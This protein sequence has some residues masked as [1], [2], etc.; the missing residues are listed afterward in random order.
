MTR[1]LMAL[2]AVCLAGCAWY[3][4]TGEPDPGDDAICRLDSD[5]LEAWICVHG[6]CVEAESGPVL[7]PPTFGACE[8]DADCLLVARAGLCCGPSGPGDYAAV[9]RDR[10]A[11]WREEH[12]C[13]DVMCEDC[14]YCPESVAHACW[15]EE[16]LEAVCAPAPEGLRC[17]AQVADP[18]ACQSDED[19]VEVDPPC[20]GC[21]VGSGEI[22]LNRDWVAA[23][24]L[25]HEFVCANVDLDCGGG[26]GCTDLPPACV[27]ERCQAASA[28]ACYDV[29]DPVCAWLDW[30]QMETF[31]NAC[32]AEC[33][34][35]EWW[36]RGEC[37]AGEGLNCGGFAGWPC[38]D[39]DLYCT[40]PGCVCANPYA[41]LCLPPGV[42]I[43][44]ED[45]LMQNLTHDACEGDWACAW[46]TCE[47][48][49]R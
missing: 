18:R 42:C 26:Q 32:E 16:C 30:E 11:D 21:E 17:M 41:G 36:H 9:H 25:L 23:W 13:A 14:G 45:C 4:D 34:G 44:A 12:G 29:W 15:G 5:C 10:V 35:A 46:D 40:C 33:A 27:E 2:S 31:A 20:C 1:W 28:C 8:V 7:D 43:I 6:Q 38:E 37:L 24:R 39:A 22:F 48:V 3:G 49:C 19:C 47:W